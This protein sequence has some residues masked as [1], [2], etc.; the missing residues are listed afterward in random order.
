MLHGGVG[1]LVVRGAHIY[2]VR[3][4]R[5]AQGVGTGEHAQERHLRLFHQRQDFDRGR[6]AHVTE[7]PED[8][9]LDEEPLGVVQAN[10]R[11]VRVVAGD[12]PNGTAVH[13]TLL[14]DM[15]QIAHGPAQRLL[16]QIAGVSLQGQRRA[17]NDLGVRHPKSSRS[18]G[19]IDF[20]IL[21]GRQAQRADR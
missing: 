13:S 18:E 19:D 8:L 3:H 10:G 21:A 1:F 2:E 17:E 16:P 5:L 20:R 9:I 11:I 7:K 12:D 14:V 4:E 15:L 6:R